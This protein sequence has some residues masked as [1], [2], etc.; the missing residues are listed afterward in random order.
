MN[1]ERIKEV[2]KLINEYFVNEYDETLNKETFYDN[3]E[4]LGLAYTNTYD[5]DYGNEIEENDFHE[6]QVSTNILNMSV[7]TYIDG[8]LLEDFRYDYYKDYKEFLTHLDF[9]EMIADAHNVY[10]IW[11]KVVA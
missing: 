10:N 9:D 6:I 4:D 7:L 5:W 2:K 11:K 3:L 1:K 8:Q